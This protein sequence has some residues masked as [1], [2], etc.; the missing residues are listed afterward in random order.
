MINRKGVGK[1]AI[2]IATL[3]LAYFYRKFTAGISALSS[4]LLRIF[5][6][7]IFQHF[8]LV[9]FGEVVPMYIIYISVASDAE[10]F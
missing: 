3:P 1:W 2:F 10:A 4:L 6:I 8:P 5:L 9:S 7:E